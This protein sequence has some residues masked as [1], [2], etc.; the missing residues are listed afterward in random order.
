[1]STVLS[2]W[3][4][5]VFAD[6]RHTRVVGTLQTAAPEVLFSADETGPGYCLLLA[7][8]WSMAATVL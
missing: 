8:I 7:K 1:M 4:P 6:G 2:V 3:Q 5:A